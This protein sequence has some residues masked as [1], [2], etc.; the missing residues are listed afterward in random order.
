MFNKCINITEIDLSS[1]NTSN[2][3]FMQNMF[4][5]CSSLTS[6]NLANF[7]TLK[8][9]DMSSMFA[10][11]SSLTSLNLSNFDTSK[12][13]YMVGMFFKCSSLTSLDLSNFNTSLVENME[14]MFQYC[15]SLTSLDL[16]NFDT[17]LVISMK[18]MFEHCSSLT[19]LN[20]SNFK[21]F[22]VENMDSMFES[23]IN[24]EYINLYNFGENKLEDNDYMMFY[25]VPENVVICINQNFSEEIIFPQIYS[26]KCYVIDCSNDW[27]SK[28][29]KII[30]NNNECIE[31]CDNSTQYKYEYN[32]KCYEN[33]SNGFLYDNHGNKTNKCKCELDK[34]LLCQNV[35]LNKSLCTKCN[36]N[37][38][39]KENDLNNLGEY[40]NCYKQ[41]EGYYLD[42]NLYKKCYHTCKICNSEGNHIIHNC[43][44]CNENYSFSIKNN[45]NNYS[46]CYQNCNYYYYF[47][48]E[49]NYHCT[50]NL[51]CPKDYSILKN[52][53]ECIK[54]DI[55][56]LIKNILENNKNI[57]EKSKEEEIKYY[58]NILEIV[59]NEFTSYNYNTS[60]LDNG[61]D[62]IIE[63][64]KLIIT[65]TTTQNQK[66]N[67]NNNMTRIDLGECEILLRNF[68]NIS[69]NETLY[70][71][72]IDI[73]QEGMKTL[74]VEYDV[75]AKLNGKNLIKLNLT[76][77]EKSKI[78]I[79]IP[80]IIN[81]DLD[82]FNSS[83]EYYNDICYT[84]TTEDGTD[85]L[86]KDRQREFID[87][88]KMICQEDCCFSEY[89]Y[90]TLVAK[91]SCDVKE[92]S[93]SFADMNINKEAIFDNF[94][95]IKNFLNFNFLICYKKL[96]TKKGILNNIGCYIII[97][98]IFFHIISIFIFS[99][100][101]FSSLKKKL[102]KLS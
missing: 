26:I 54:S 47:D 3:N 2:V 17:S 92:S 28:Q 38:Y 16:S 94:K 95:N 58:D 63:S 13:S 29:K 35:A 79:L 72:K 77:C 7:N 32:G 60:N 74:K 64:E 34:C 21:T 25:N 11:C 99:L 42:D 8:V 67:E 69:I 98:I 50:M 84:T 37:Y 86:L 53:M 80:I 12:V 33:C 55:L 83:S 93:K 23:C 56:D 48:N 14:D 18:N 65:F 10:L 45:N 85:I 46:N 30:N 78:S 75:Y 9:T 44:E 81:E 62:E 40:I 6:L 101:Q 4:Y 91:C 15:L 19:S 57:T 96:F 82:I 22:Q 61:K 97:S 43:I 71:K 70:L 27:K 20:L 90:D 88:N 66:N 36:T 39:P 68:Y 1:F 89:N 87:Q 24:L 51:S 31:S 100:K 73:I 41:P 102:K 59:E 52:K 49:N 76:V 5:G